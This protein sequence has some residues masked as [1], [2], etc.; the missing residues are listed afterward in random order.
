M[1]L[2]PR[3]P[4]FTNEFLGEEI[5]VGEVMCSIKN[6][7]TSKTVSTGIAI[8]PTQTLRENRPDVAS[9]VVIEDCGLQPGADVFPSKPLWND[10][11]AEHE[12]IQDEIRGVNQNL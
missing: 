7:V 12:P 11:S 4:V 2:K 5:T 1:L 8:S 3:F 9:T 6:S 10:R